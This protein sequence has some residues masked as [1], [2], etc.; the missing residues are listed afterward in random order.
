M[1]QCSAHA[2][3]DASRQ[4]GLPHLRWITGEEGF[5]APIH[6]KADT[7]AGGLPQAASADAS[8]EASDAV[9]C[10]HCP[11]SGRQARVPVQTRADV[12][13]PKNLQSLSGGRPEE[14]L[15]KARAHA[16]KEVNRG[17]WRASCLEAA[18][19]LLVGR[20]ADGPLA[21]N[22][23]K[24]SRQA[25]VEPAYALQFVDV[26][27]SSDWCDACFLYLA[28]RLDGVE[29]HRHSSFGGTRT[30]SSQTSNHGMPF[31]LSRGVGAPHR[32]VWQ[33]C[34]VLL[35]APDG[36]PGIDTARCS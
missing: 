34:G 11:H 28:V 31:R 19:E 17:F 7:N 2:T 5:D 21:S 32:D 18:L 30:E 15:G 29:G 14:G 25:K 33:Q 22:L 26:P 8:V 10:G 35:S 3:S 13:L 16:G 27:R 12:V 24:N 23:Y 36:A 20:P 6:C 1:V 9:L 4:S